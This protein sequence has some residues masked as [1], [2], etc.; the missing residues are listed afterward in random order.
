MLGLSSRHQTAYPRS[1]TPRQLVWLALCVGLVLAWSATGPSGPVLA[2]V[3]AAA[4][5][6][7][8]SMSGKRFRTERDLGRKIWR[9]LTTR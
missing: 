2:A 9:A 8:L 4:L 6:I 5:V 1:M 7:S 3:V